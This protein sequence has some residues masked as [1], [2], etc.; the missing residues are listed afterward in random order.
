MNTLCLGQSFVARGQTFTGSNRFASSRA[1]NRMKAWMKGDDSASRA[2]SLEEQMLG[3]RS[4]LRKFC[5][6]SSTHQLPKQI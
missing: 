2:L 6:W 4:Q 5:E 3:G 1:V